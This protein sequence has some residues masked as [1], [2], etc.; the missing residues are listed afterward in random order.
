MSDKPAMLLLDDE[1]EILNALKRLFRKE[2]DVDLFTEGQAALDAIKEKEYAIILSDMRMPQLDGAAFLAQAKDIAPDSSRIL[3][4]GYADMESTIR[5]INEG[6]IFS[7]VSKPWDNEELKVLVKNALA[8]FKLIRKN[9]ELSGKLVAA[10]TKLTEANAKLEERI[11]ARTAAL[12]KQTARLKQSTLKQRKFFRQLLDMI[13]L[14]IEDRAGHENGHSKRV[15]A[16]SKVLAEEL[17][18]SRA[19]A[20][21]IYLTGLLHEVGKV[22]ISDQLLATIEVERNN[23]ENLAFKSHAV[24]GAK[25]LEKLPSLHSVAQNIRHQY[26][27]YDGS[28]F[29]DNL[30]KEDIPFGARILKVV[31]DYDYL[32]L[33]HKHKQKLS[34]DRAQFYLKEERGKQY[35]YKIVD[36]YLSLL[37]RLPEIDELE[38][39]YCVATNKLE[40]GM[41]VSADVLTNKGG[42]MLTKDT[43]LTE[44]AIKK[45]IEYEEDNDCYLTIFIY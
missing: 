6:E 27:N 44:A 35:D 41:I 4:T 28:G 34:P 43:E 2:Y 36:C 5:A 23:E 18:L 21:N 22:S 12:N 10:N 39:D 8:R 11:A 38:A 42:I 16:H 7:Y 15:A 19:E 40:P 9:E 45:L 14:I 33:G 30:K 3:L 17:G 1:K 26:E 13:G 24:E 20:I 25:I 31:S 29:P 37:E 32:L